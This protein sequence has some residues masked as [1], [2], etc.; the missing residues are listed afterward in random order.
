M[1]QILIKFPRVATSLDV[2]FQMCLYVLQLNANRTCIMLTLSLSLFAATLPRHPPCNIVPTPCQLLDRQALSIQ[3]TVFANMLLIALQYGQYQQNRYNSLGL[4]IS[5]HCINSALIH[6]LFV[7]NSS[8]Q[9]S[10]SCV[11]TF[12]SQP[13]KRFKLY[14]TFCYIRTE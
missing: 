8:L 9:Q 1:A 14:R 5:I 11:G 4:T 2:V 6:F 13:N 3:H 12:T 7:H 10:S